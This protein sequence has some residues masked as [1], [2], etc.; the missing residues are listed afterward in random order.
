MNNKYI[1]LPT[2]IMVALNGE[3]HTIHSS[4]EHFEEIKKLLERGCFNIKDLI[5]KAG[6]IKEYCGT[7]VT[8]EA[9]IVYFNDKP[10][11]NNI[12]ARIFQMYKAG[13]DVSALT[14]FLTK[15]AKNPD[16]KIMQQIDMFL[17]G[18]H[19][20]IG[21]DGCLYAYKA[22][23]DNYMDIYS[24]TIDNSVGN[25]VK[26][27]R[28]DVDNDSNQGCSHGLHCGNISYVKSY[29]GGNSTD[30]RLVIVR[31]E[32]EN[33]VSVP[34][35]H[36]FMKVRCC[37]YKVVSEVTWDYLLNL[38]VQNDLNGP[39]V[40]SIALDE[41]QTIEDAP[42]KVSNTPSKWSNAEDT[43]LYKM[44]D[45]YA[46]WNEISDKIGRSVNA[47]QKRFKRLNN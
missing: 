40:L 33:I 36:S 28:K 14:N 9:G 25:I 38:T 5:D 1:I 4:H 46:T 20:P 26:V 43:V 10:I 12:T 6:V 32:P 37:E 30:N 7:E 8:V 27:D 18:V 44:Y 31:V 13:D 22:V 15:V 34:K 29:G 39:E 42:K 3:P 41:V 45:D 47:C 19:I 11:H 35:D 23:R 24:G 2:S 16:S 17:Q 21:K